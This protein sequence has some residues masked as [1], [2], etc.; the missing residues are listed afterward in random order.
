M[1]NT[2]RVGHFQT[3]AG[4]ETLIDLETLDEDE[5]ANTLQTPSGLLHFALM[6]TNQMIENVFEVIDVVR[7]G[8]HILGL[9]LPSNHVSRIIGH[10]LLS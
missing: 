9:S 4:G 8:M 7:P 10:W 2:D 3:V 6:T 5:K 1:R